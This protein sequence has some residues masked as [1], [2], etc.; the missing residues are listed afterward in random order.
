MDFALR[1]NS[2]K[3]RTQLT[4]R[5]VVTTCSHI[6]CS[7]CSDSLGLTNPAGASR[8]CPA[9][10]TALTQPDDAVST[11]LQP[12]EDYKTSVLS[13]LSPSTIM[14]CAGRGLAFWSY[15]ST[16]EIVYQEFLAKTLTDKY[17]N[18][19]QQLDQVLSDANSELN[20]LNQRISI[21]MQIEQ[22]RLKQENTQLVT[23]FREK[24]HKHQQTQ[25][26]YERLKRKEMTAATQS[27]AFESADE[28]LG[29][30]SSQQRFISPQHHN[31]RAR[32][33]R[34]L[35]VDHNGIEKIHTHRR[36][37]SSNS[38][39]MMPPLSFP[40][41]GGLQSNA[42]GCTNPI[43]THSN[44]RT[45]LGPTSQTSSRLGTGGCRNSA[46]LLSKTAPSQT[47]SYRQPFA[48]LHTNTINKPSVSGHGM[49]AGMKIGRQAS[50]RNARASQSSQNR[51][52]D[53]PGLFSQ[54]ER[55][56][57]DGGAYY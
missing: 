45:Q 10:Q 32:A 13:G 24:C 16:Q 26:L 39:G 36:S 44:H 40:R 23:A 41:A 28:V 20:I 22:D 6:F 46:S 49:S 27:V 14:E 4:E 1:C 42:L 38:G 2:L 7:H 55:F 30:V 9:C 43:P 19:N 35:Q 53:Q 21:D 3:C 50:P 33:Q 15:Q 57:R 52:S 54:N 12:T 51:P 8:V 34:D 29:K 17:S 5:A 48:G 18:L 47:P 56:Q 25:E 11:S 31:P 37:G